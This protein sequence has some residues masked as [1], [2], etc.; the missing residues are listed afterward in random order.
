MTGLI[1]DSWILS[2]LLAFSL[3]QQVVWFP[4]ISNQKRAFLDNCGQS[5]PAPRHHLTGS[6]FLKVRCGMWARAVD[7]LSPGAQHP[8]CTAP[9]RVSHHLPVLWKV[10]VCCTE[11]TFQTLACF[12]AEDERSSLLMST[13][14]SLGKSWSW[15]A[16]A[17]VVARFPEF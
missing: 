17:M 12:T 13:P 11:Q 10:W 9:P 7:V 15:G 4:Q 14:F 5:S 6:S 1:E 8:I 2:L 16:Q 3:S